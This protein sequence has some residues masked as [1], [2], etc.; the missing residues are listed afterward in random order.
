MHTASAAMTTAMQAGTNGPVNMH[1]MSPPSATAVHAPSQA[2][3]ATLHALICF[4]HFAVS[5]RTTHTLRLGPSSGFK[6]SDTR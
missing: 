6:K 4:D 2:S 5:M 1:A 3:A